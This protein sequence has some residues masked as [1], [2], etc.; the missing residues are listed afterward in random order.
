MTAITLLGA[1]SPQVIQINLAYTIAGL[2][3]IVLGA[4]VAWGSLKQ[5][6][7]HLES[8]VKEIKDDLKR[9]SQEFT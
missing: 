6:V 5:S 7:K 1:A 3:V 9:I 4:G 8:D 2:L